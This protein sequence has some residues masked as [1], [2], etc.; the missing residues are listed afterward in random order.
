MTVRYYGYGL[1][2]M[3]VARG[4]RSGQKNEEVEEKQPTYVSHQVPYH[5]YLHLQ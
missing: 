1:E 3:R 4:V 5:K 2:I